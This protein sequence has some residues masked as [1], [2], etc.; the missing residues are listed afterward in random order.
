MIER[1]ME[2][3]LIERR[4]QLEALAEEFETH[5]DFAKARA[6]GEAFD[7]TVADGLDE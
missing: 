7:V 1:L 5:P 4:K 3:A 2:G 6:D